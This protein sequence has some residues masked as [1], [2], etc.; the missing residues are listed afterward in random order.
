MAVT[1]IPGA[2]E[3]LFVFAFLGL[4]AGGFALLVGGRRALGI[5]GLVAVLVLLGGGIVMWFAVTGTSV[6][7]AEV[8]GNA[9]APDVLV[10][11]PGRSAISTPV[12]PSRTVGTSSPPAVADGPW[13]PSS[14]YD[15]QAD[16]YPSERSAAI[17]LA[18]LLVQSWGE[19]LPEGVAQP[20]RLTIRGDD[21]IDEEVLPAVADAIRPRLGTIR[22]DVEPT[23]RAE[24]DDRPPLAMAERAE[25]DYPVT[26]EVD[27]TFTYAY[28]GRGVIPSLK[29][30]GKL[31]VSLAG[32]A[33]ATKRTA[34][35]V[36][37]P[38]VDDFAVFAS[39]NPHSRC[40]VARSPDACISPHEAE[41]Q[42]IASAVALLYPQ[43]RDRVERTGARGETRSAGQDRR[44]LE[45]TIEVELR[46]GR[47]V[48]D[49]F[50]QRFR[51]SYG[52]RWREAILVETSDG[53]ITRLA[54]ACMGQVNARAVQREAARTA[55]TRTA[56]KVAGLTVLICL[57]Y[58]FLNAATKGYYAWS[59]RAAAVVAALGVLFALIWM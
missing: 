16:V 40:L 49:R 20:T 12:E 33:G 46:R 24:S 34:N 43:V 25:G 11:P 29:K 45:K 56:L 53:N 2:V 18:R 58:L 4:I 52:E 37:K 30:S 55:W 44:Q 5:A 15:S 26:M 28:G 47:L 9:I 59:L 6:S 54:Q 51:R 10:L 50:V 23:P 14:D 39:R 32:P 13:L 19:V 21:E 41:Q 35:L 1:G 22:I 42:A 7:V 27:G 31:E 36:N 3:L 38:W 8:T 17:A 57:L 48:A